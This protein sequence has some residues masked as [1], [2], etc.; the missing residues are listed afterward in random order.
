MPPPA[1]ATTQP[2]AATRRAAL[3][4]AVL[5]IALLTIG[6]RIV[7]LV[8][9]D[10]NAGVWLDSVR[11]DLGVCGVLVGLAWLLPGLAASRTGRAIALSAVQAMALLVGL[12][13]LMGHHLY[14][15]TGS[16][17][18]AALL[19]FTADRAV[20][21]WAVIR[22]ETP[23]A[24]LI[25]TCIGALALLAAPWLFGQP[26]RT[27]DPANRPENQ[28]A[29]AEHTPPTAVATLGLLTA[30]LAA[31][32]PPVFAR[33]RA[34]AAGITPRVL[35]STLKNA[36]APTAN[37]P[38]ATARWDTSRARLVRTEAGPPRHVAI[39]ILES[40]GASSVQPWGEGP[41]DTSVLAAM[42]TQST[43][44]LRAHAVVPHTSKAL[45]ALLCGIEP[46]L[47]MLATE[48]MPDG[49]PGRCLAH[50]LRGVGY[51]AAFF[52]SATGHFEGRKGLISNLG[53]AEF[54]PS[55]R[56]PKDGFER[57]NY[58]GFEDA[59][60]LDPSAIWLKA[61]S[62]KPTFTTFLTLTPHHD[63]LAPRRYGRKH[64]TDDTE[65]NRYLNAVHYVDGFAGEVL[66]R[67]REAGLYD[68]TLFFIVGDH[69]EAFGQ[70]GLKQHDAVPYQ[71]VLHVPWLMIDGRNPSKPQ[72]IH[73]L[74]SHLDALP[75]LVA[76]L[77]FDI[78]D[79]RYPGQDIRT[80]TGD[81]PLRASCWYERRCA[82]AFDGT[83]KLIHH[84][85]EQP[86]EL[87]DLASDPGETRDLAE[88]PGHQPIIKEL[89]AAIHSWKGGV[90]E[91]YRRHHEHALRAQLLDQPPEV[92]HARSAQFGKHLRLLGYD[93]MPGQAPGPGGLIRMA[94][95][96]HVVDT[97]PAGTKLFVRLRA[98]SG[99]LHDVRHV[100]L[101]GRF[102][103]ENWRSGGYVVD[104]VT[105]GLPGELTGAFVDVLA[106]L[107][108]A[109][110]VPI[111][112][113]GTDRVGGRA[114]VARVWL[115]DRR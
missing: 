83:R 63:Y 22:S 111:E 108:D 91:L 104:A 74:V 59:I 43:V 94:M 36:P 67:Y 47:Q 71:E 101:G 55:E 45:V 92:R 1:T 103:P 72:K 29:R 30:L 112:A 6:L 96:W 46:H 57:A 60:M 9:A 8:H 62:Q 80:L 35:L 41:P 79:A 56:F 27:P 38:T 113:T 84:Y 4:F 98:E 105:V 32:L 23:T 68:D 93:V 51:E 33:D 99:E 77:G 48:G 42:A 19:L 70:H 40:T 39:I 3:R 54:Y 7:R 21:I 14:M 107:V 85:G 97:M 100:P 24:L 115:G 66:R 13:E 53:Y 26:L 28:P 61:R 17:L 95:F 58:F 76:W 89:L 88:D 82:A 73:H 15:R 2:A 102:P 87:F 86:D 37:D 75:T 25:G 106:E 5:P 69:G 12:L 20:D 65:H 81:R 90:N 110:G 78:A 31:I 64:Y 109:D 16:H 114:H 18:D 50:L 34:F 10:A 49:L 44:A 11:A 52:Q